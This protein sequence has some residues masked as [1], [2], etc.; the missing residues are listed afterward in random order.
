MR[1]VH[2]IFV[3]VMQENGEIVVSEPR[4]HIHGYGATLEE[5][6]QDFRQVLVGSFDLLQEDQQALGPLPQGQLFYLQSI[7]VPA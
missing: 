7:I 4:Y 5:A 1:L 2:N 3:L 6:K